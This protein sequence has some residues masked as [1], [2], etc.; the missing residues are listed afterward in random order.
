MADEP[1]MI[2]EYERPI[3]RIMADAHGDAFRPIPS[4][5]EA[6]RVADGRV[7]LEGDYG[8]QVYLTCPAALVRCSSEVLQQLLLDIDAWCWPGNDGHGAGVYFEQKPV[9]AGVW[10]GM[11]GGIIA[12]GLWLHAEVEGFGIRD[13]VEAVLTGGRDRLET[14]AAPG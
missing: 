2:P 10:G 5:E 8:G 1:E 3:G 12:D 6:Q 13:Q 11:G 7:I 14:A 9:G 4:L